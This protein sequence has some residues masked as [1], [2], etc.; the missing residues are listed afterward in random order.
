MEKDYRISR[1]SALK[2]VA[3]GVLGSAAIPRGVRAQEPSKPKGNLNQSVCKWCYKD[4]ALD[5]LARESARI[6]IKSVELLTPEEWPVVK[7]YGL[8]CAMGSEE[9][10]VGKECCALCRS[11][12]SPYH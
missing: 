4:T 9:R 7:K 10:R 1:R 6:G 3:T 2:T 11:R 8:T 5:A 12:W